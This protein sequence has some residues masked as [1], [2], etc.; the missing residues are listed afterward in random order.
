M[1]DEAPRRDEDDPG[2]VLIAEAAWLSLIEA[3]KTMPL[4]FVSAVVAYGIV[5]AIGLGLAAI[6]PAVARAL[7]AITPSGAQIGVALVTG[8]L[9]CV[10][11]AAVAVPMHTLVLRNTRQRGIVSLFDAVTLR[12]AFWVALLSWVSTALEFYVP[13][14]GY[15]IVMF[16]GVRFG[17]LFPAIAL[18]AKG[19]EWFARL[20]ESWDL[21]SGR[22][23][24]ILGA[25]LL[26][27]LPVTVIGVTVVLVLLALGIIPD[28]TLMGDVQTPGAIA[29]TVIV[30]NLIGVFGTA[31]TSLAIAW[32]Y[33]IVQVKRAEA[34]AVEPERGVEPD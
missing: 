15:L 30:Q 33:R 13:Y 25:A 26:A 19:G 5:Q 20:G 28:V 1:T 8:T 14:V 34:A 27:T 7:P 22:F 32:N 9:S 24:R 11:L 10:V 21:T 16:F 2:A 18:G 23:W 31:F 17:F 29:S 3:V 12:F 6:I 4:V